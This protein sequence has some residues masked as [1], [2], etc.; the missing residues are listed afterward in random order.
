MR[1]TQTHGVDVLADVLASTRI[2]GTVFCRS[3]LTGPWGM[4]FEP[5][6]RAGLHVVARGTCWLRLRGQG[7]PLRLSQGDVILLPHGAGHSL[8]SDPGVLP[9]PF[10]QVLERCRVSQGPHGMSMSLEGQGASTVLLCGA[11]SFEHEGVHPLLSLLPRLIHI[12]ADAGH[13]AGPLKAVLSLLEAEYMQPEP[14]SVAATARL[15][16]VLFIHVVRGWL[17]GQP[18]GR[19]GWLGAVRDAQVGRALA[20][21]HGEPQ[22]AWAV[23]ALAAEVACSRAT[24]ARRFRELV[25]EPP[26]VYLT[27]LRMDVAARLLRESEGSLSEIAGRVGYASEFAFNRTFHRVRGVP[28]GRYREQSREAS[29]MERGAGKVRGRLGARGKAARSAPRAARDS[30]P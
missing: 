16:D 14:G 15:V 7:K 18:E 6:S 1:P 21:M 30:F 5:A 28:P 10:T 8:L 26:L 20:L 29:L 23:D 17:A 11:Y 12:P 19:A 27:R 3:E 9:E 25:G 24:F 13:M 4:T 2:G 22:R